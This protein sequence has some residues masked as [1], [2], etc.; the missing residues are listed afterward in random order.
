MDAGNFSRNIVD[1]FGAPNPIT[2]EEMLFY[3]PENSL[4]VFRPDS[5]AVVQVRAAAHP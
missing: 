4:D 3:I 1:W 2:A 5:R